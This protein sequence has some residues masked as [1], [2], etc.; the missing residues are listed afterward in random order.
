MRGAHTDPKDQEGPPRM[1][2]IPALSVMVFLHKDIGYEVLRLPVIIGLPVALLAVFYWFGSFFRTSDIVWLFAPDNWALGA[3]AVAFG[4]RAMY[5]RHAHWEALKKGLSYPTNSPGTSYLGHGTN[6]STYRFVEPAICL[7][8]G[9]LVKELISWPLGIWLM[10]SGIA[11]ALW[12]RLMWRAQLRR[13][14]E[15]HD[16][17]LEGE[18]LSQNAEHFT[19]PRPSETR[20]ES[21]PTGLEDGDMAPERGDGVRPG[22]SHLEA[23]ERMRRR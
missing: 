3:F 6:A 12:E 22:E 16:T 5:L 11:L 13:H 14:F 1:V 20:A 4:L 15:A 17:I 8:V 2:T 10:W 18:L 9:Y 7:V 23:L 21:I 19:R